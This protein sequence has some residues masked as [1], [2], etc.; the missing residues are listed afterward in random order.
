M[1]RV[2]WVLASD[3]VVQLGANLRALK[4]KQMNICKRRAVVALGYVAASAT[5]SVV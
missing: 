4:Y 1:S 3:D 5:A 2:P